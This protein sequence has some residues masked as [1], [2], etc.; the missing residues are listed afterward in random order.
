[1]SQKCKKLMIDRTKIPEIHKQNDIKFPEFEEAQLSNG[2][3]LFL[4]NDKRYPVITLK[5]LIK[6]GSY[7]DFFVENG[8]FGLSN[9][10]A[11]LLNKGT[12]KFTANDISEIIDINGAIFSSGAGYDNSY[13]SISCLKENFGNIWEVLDDVMQD[14]IF[15]Q[16]EFDNKKEQLISSLS[17]LKDDG[18]FL[19]ERVFKSI[20]YKNTPYSHDPE[21]GSKSLMNIYTD[22]V[23][24]FYN[25]NYCSENF[26][27]AIIGD[28]NKEEIIK[29]FEK[30]IRKKNASF[31]DRYNFPDLSNENSVYI[32]NKDDAT[33]ACLH[34]GH[35]GIARNNADY[36]ILN[37]LNVILGGTFTSRINY[38]LREKN[39][40]TY[41]A[42]TSFNCRKYG[43]DFSIETELNI[44]KTAF[45]ISEIIK[46]M[47][48]LQTEYVSNDEIETA[49]NY[50]YGNYPLQ[51]ESYSN[52]ASRLLTLD[53][54]GVEK[55][56]YNSYL[57]NISKITKEDIFVAANKYLKSDNLLISVCGN[58]KK[59]KKDL[60]NFGKIEIIEDIE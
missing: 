51:F 53:L 12:N 56:F 49:K 50:I 59:L 27:I 21:G 22:D 30:T 48:L 7:V 24:K 46:E 4:V 6:A 44:D 23:I 35:S 8:K 43:G 20:L 55:N 26:V 60:T 31:I 5:I 34:I 41:G 40:L 13:V 39:G 15:P 16:I 10:T 11:E 37:F 33:Q 25:E 2:V 18:S 54:Y 38:N 45:A 9:I 17:S 1:M 47:K 36:I 3:K 57:E 32:I 28:F 14:P 58:I 29:I 42:R 19:A 52:V